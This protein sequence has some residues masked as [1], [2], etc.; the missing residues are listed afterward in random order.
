MTPHHFRAIALSLPEA[1][2]G[3]H[4]G[5]A[6][7]R[8][9]GRI[10]A[11]LTPELGLGMVKLN[12][13]QQEMLCAAEPSIFAP[14]PGGWGRRGS[15]HIRLAAA[16]EA[17]VRSALATAFRNVAP[18]SLASRI[19]G[20]SPAP[21]VVRPSIRKARLA[22]AEAMGRMVLRAIEQ[23]NAKDYEPAAILALKASLTTAEIERRMGERLVYVAMIG[24]ELVGTASLSVANRRVHSVFVDP[25]RQR[26]GIG[27]ALIA[28]IEKLAR[29]KGLD[30]LVLASSLTAIPFYQRL[31]YE[32]GQ[33][34]VRQGGV[35]TLWMSKEL[36]P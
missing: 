15:T 4:M 8:A 1:A 31:G 18:K 16:D 24:G 19:D 34:E 13:E 20:A 11:T 22:D 7:F 32:S 23:T 9:R 10:F 36:R 29:R 28:V 14:V 27:A 5:R 35:E 12:V 26:A 30:R 21:Q 33:R 3:S 17:T 25:S 2:Q 6:D